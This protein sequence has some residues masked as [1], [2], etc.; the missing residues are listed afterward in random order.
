[1]LVYLSWTGGC[2]QEGLHQCRA[3]TSL[4]NDSRARHIAAVV[5]LQGDRLPACCSITS[6]AG[7]HSI[8]SLLA[9]A[10][11]HRQMD[12]SETYELPV[13][14]LDFTSFAALLV[15][16]VQACQIFSHCSIA[17]L[18]RK[19]SL[20]ERLYCPAREAHAAHRWSWESASVRSLRSKNRTQG[21]GK[22]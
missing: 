14:I 21:K 3:G 20:S 7:L 13:G 22:I 16:T 19:E 4:R 10:G 1:M 9:S 8:E 5:S 2:D 12:T 11:G 18:A 6:K 15:F 17:C